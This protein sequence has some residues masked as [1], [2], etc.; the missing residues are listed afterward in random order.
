[1]E[2]VMNLLKE[3]KKKKIFEQRKDKK[4]KKNGQEKKTERGVEQCINLHIK[5]VHFLNMLLFPL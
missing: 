4:K 1:M 3:K 5:I 2:C